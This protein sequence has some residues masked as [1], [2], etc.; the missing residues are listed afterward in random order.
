MI[1]THLALNH[2]VHGYLDTISCCKT[3][4]MLHSDPTVPC[5]LRNLQLERLA[6]Q[7]EQRVQRAR[8]RSQLSQHIINSSGTRTNSRELVHKYRACYLSC[9]AT[10]TNTERTR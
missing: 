5:S 6:R 7:T 10:R 8:L 1:K 2:S 4:L 3:Y 9:P